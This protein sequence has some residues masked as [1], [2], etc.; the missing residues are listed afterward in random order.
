MTEEKK[1]ALLDGSYQL[2]INGKW[3]DGSSGETFPSINPANEE[4]IAQI[5]KGTAADAEEAVMAAKQAFERGDWVQMEK[6]KREKILLK[7]ADLIESKYAEELAVRE[8]SDAGKLY[9]DV[10]AVDVKDIANMLRYYAGWI[11]KLDGRVKNPDGYFNHHLLGY[12]RREPLGVVVGITPYNFPL[13]LSMSKIAPAL[14]MGNSF[15]HKPASATPL[16]AN[17]LAKVFDEAGVPAGVYNLVTGSGRDVGQTFTTHPEVDKI[18]LTGST[19]TGI[20]ISKDAADSMKHLTMELGGKAPM[21]IFEDADLDTA[22]QYAVM[23]AFWNKGEVCVAATRIIVQQSIYE[24]FLERFIKATSQLKIGDPFDPS[25]DIGPMVGKG[26]YEKALRYIQIG[27]EEDRAQLVLGGKAA[28]VHDKG[29]FVEP[30]IFAQARA[31]MRISQE[32][33]FGPVVPVI[34]F[35]DFEDALA[36][37]NGIRVGLA[38]GVHSSDTAKAIRFGERLQAG[39]IWINTWHEY[40]VNMPFGGYKMSGYGR[41]RG[42]EALESYTQVKSMWVK[43]GEQ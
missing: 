7:A 29:Y 3:K 43:L 20:R 33:I 32:E 40:D 36:I 15:I 13:I 22:V 26:E 11:N 4:V 38:A 8:T 34:P 14:A 28:S 35:K 1:Q 17:T 39:I 24:E 2:F 27:Q 21:V 30:T 25:T 41:E 23:G 10:M 12:T 18:A 6:R 9:R 42:I 16:S 5:A 19:E 31:D 37:A